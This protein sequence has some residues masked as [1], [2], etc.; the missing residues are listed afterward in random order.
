MRED[1][2]AIF[3]RFVTGEAR[4]VQCFIAG[5]T[6]PKVGEPPAARGGVLF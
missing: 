6:V 5:F 2:V 4:F 3:S 1:K